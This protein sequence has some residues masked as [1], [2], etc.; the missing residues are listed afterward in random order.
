MITI[1]PI[2]DAGV[3]VSYYEKDDYYS[4]GGADPDAQGEWF[5][6]GAARLG[7]SG[8]VDRDD[9]KS[10]LEG[11]LPDGQQLGT[12]REAGGP[13]EH[14]LGYDL[15]FSAPKSVTLVAELGGDK[16]V[17]EAHQSAVRTA[18]GWIESNIAA[19]RVKS[20]GEIHREATGNLVIATFQH[21]T[22]RNHDPQLHTHSVVIN[23][24]ERDDGKWRSLDGKAFFESQ[25]ASTAV[26]RSAL[27]LEL[28]RLGY[29]LETE[30]RDGSF[31]IAGVSAQA[32]AEFSTRRAEI[33]ASLKERGLGPEA[34]SQAAL[35]TRHAKTVEDRAELAKE[36]DAR[37]AAIGFDPQTVIADARE[38]GDQTNP[39]TAAESRKA[40]QSAISRLSDQET[41]F[42]HAN[43][44][45]WTLAGAVG[46]L[47]VS[48]AE[49][50]I[51]AEKAAGRLHDAQLGPQRG[52]VTLSAV[53]Q[54]ERIQ[55]SMANGRDAVASVY[56]ADEA[57][58]VMADLPSRRQREAEMARNAALWSGASAES[59]AKIRAG[60]LNEG[61]TQA[62]EM[63][64]ST[65]DRIVGVLGRP[66]TG[67][68]FML[69]EARA[70]LAERGFNLVGMAMNAEAARQLESSAGIA[71]H[72]ISRH[73]KTLGEDAARLRSADPA[74][75]AEI[76]ATYAK[77][78]WVV[79]EA[80]QV[81]NQK[82]R[83]LTT[84]AEKLGARMV[85]VGDP[86]Q[87]GA[88]QAGKPFAR[89]LA[90]G[91]QHREMDEIRRQADPR[92]VSA[93]RDVLAK[94]F[95]AALEKLAPETREIADRSDRLRAMVS[96]WSATGDARD[97]TLM[98]SARNTTRTELND[99]ARDV[100]RSEGKLVGEKPAR[101]LQS[102]YAQRADTA[103]AS[104][105]RAGQTVQFPRA[106]RSLG[107]GA[108]AYARVESVDAR[109]GLVYLDV[110]GR[111]VSWVPGQV[112]GGSKIPPSIFVE[113]E[114]TLA[115]GERITWTKNDSGLGLT[116]GQRLTVVSTDE[117]R[118][119]VLTEDGRRVEVDRGVQSGRH[120]EHGYATTIYK[121]Q[122]QTASQVLV[123]AASADKSLLT[124]K[125]F[126]VAVSRQTEGLTIYTDS[127]SKLRDSV[128]ERT[129]DKLSALDSRISVPLSASASVSDATD[130]V[131]AAAFRE[132]DARR[133]AERARAPI[134][135]PAR[136]Q[137]I[138]QPEIKR[139]VASRGLD[140]ER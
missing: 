60:V 101:Q 73:Q 100:L 72:T 129:G 49:R 40:L 55:A 62:V 134:P 38:R 96:A 46:R 39:L 43:L 12:I 7:L 124:Q 78:V 116:N 52:Y 2:S 51:A 140:M 47:S 19:T 30:G 5:G 25:N 29:Q 56:P 28:Q 14:R 77:Q 112:A 139:P 109:I 34:S 57:S 32:I 92:H 82:M 20:S 35:M 83:G 36:W 4:A 27:A 132:S 115:A 33:T 26:Y 95:G 8:A 99:M 108:G 44:L 127:A 24:T 105:Y 68:T 66:G 63:I 86:D 91:M 118:M 125:A 10:L 81:N 70:L 13:V 17:I 114:T 113:R 107:V 9:F 135:V 71:S 137:R 126:L 123:D 111:R 98:L 122:G 130:R 18:L 42:T 16:A 15:T 93:I 54:E 76:R 90:N 133:E 45:A 75:A 131:L 97:S 69:G 138:P 50:L 11:Q 87:L 85:L 41:A 37:A 74:R 61:Q 110:G 31:E 104:T 88:I 102:V 64:L 1:G 67:K 120:W 53:Q 136:E 59:V 6:E 119:T 106:L 3:A 79:D 89:M 48:D 128:S 84:L 58:R 103:I 65:S 21:D 23:A 22:N 117:R 121:S 94:D 80:S